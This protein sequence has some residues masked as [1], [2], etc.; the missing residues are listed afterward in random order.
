MKAGD[1]VFVRGNS[2][3]SDLV[4]FFDKGEFSHVAIAVSST[5]VLEANWYMRVRIREMKYEDIEII[6][7]GFTREERNKVVQDGI[8]F[9]GLY[10]DYFQ[11]MG[12]ILQKLFSLEGGNK[13]NSPK[14]LICSELIFMIL[15]SMGSKFNI[16]M[17]IGYD[18]TPNQLYE[19]LKDYAV[20]PE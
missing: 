17:E 12:Y 4:R 10:Y 5:H 15:V 18:V 20:S 2:P 1:I 19:I 8:A 13:F 14:N 11:I 16:A 3:L 6:D 9:I 7:L